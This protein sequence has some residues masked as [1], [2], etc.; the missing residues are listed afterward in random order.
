[1]MNAANK[2]DSI[3]T[4]EDKKEYITGLREQV[5]GIY[6]ITFQNYREFREVYNEKV[7][8]TEIVEFWMNQYTF[9][10]ENDELLIYN[11]DHENLVGRIY[12]EYCQYMM[13]K[14]VDTG[15]LTLM[16]DKKKK[17]V[18]WKKTAV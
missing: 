1:M 14:L 4:I 18:F 15:H 10:S 3:I 7:L 16:W 17:I 2:V 11:S 8:T 6:L 9:L 5:L 12:K 13:N